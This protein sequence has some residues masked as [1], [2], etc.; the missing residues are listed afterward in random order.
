M[1]SKLITIAVILFGMLGQAAFGLTSADKL[2]VVTTVP[3]LAWFASEIGGEQVDVT[4]LSKGRENL[5]SL[6][7]RPTTLVSISKADLLIEMGLSLEV[8]WLPELVM[9]SRNRKVHVGQPGRVTCGDGWEAIDVPTDLSREG[10]DLHPG[11]NPH[12]SLSPLAGTHMADHVLRGLVAVAPDHEQ[13]FRERHKKLTE[14]LK[15]AEKRWKRYAALFEQSKAKEMAVSYHAEFDYLLDFLGVG[16]ELYIEPKPGV[17]PT[18]GHLAK[19][20]S[21]MREN[22]VPMVLTTNWSNSKS[23][24]MAATR[25]GAKVSELPTMVHGTPWASDW[26][27]LIDGLLERL[28]ID[29]GLPELEPEG[30]ENSVL[31]R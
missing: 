1:D 13:K 27:L 10:G 17:P 28:R 4:S 25:A 15:K 18:A 26:I 11:G 29:Y 6:K 3:D 31:I 30:A 16:I 21:H 5:H 24:S 8:T 19:V 7:V 9:A 23:V 20:I 22:S 14:R 2:K 12:F